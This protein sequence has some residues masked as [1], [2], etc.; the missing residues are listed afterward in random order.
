MPTKL[1][2][3]VTACT[4]GLIAASGFTLLTFRLPAG[5]DA[6]AP[7][8]R[9]QCGVRHNRVTMDVTCA[10]SSSGANKAQQICIDHLGFGDRHAV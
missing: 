7:L 9:L 8:C 2:R 1:R 6:T 3:L 10:V 5:F 4:L